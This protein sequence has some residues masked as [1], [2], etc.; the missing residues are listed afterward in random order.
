M[1]IECAV[2]S[3][4]GKLRSENEDNYFLN[5]IIRK[6]VTK[7]RTE[8]YLKKNGGKF[9]FAVCDGMGGEEQGELASLCSVKAMDVFLK[10]K[11]TEELYEHFLSLARK[12]IK[13]NTPVLKKG[14]PGTT[15]GLL[16]LEDNMAYAANLGDSRIYLWRG[17]ALRQLSKDHTQAQLMVDYGL[18]PKEEAREHQGGHVL[19]RCLSMD[20]DIS[21]ADFYQSEPID[22]YTDD[23]FLLC[24]DGLTDMLEDDEIQKC[25]EQY[26]D[27]N[28]GGQAQELCKRALL[29]GGKDNVTCLL[30]KI[31]QVQSK[32]KNK[33]FKRF[34]SFGNK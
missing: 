20:M 31:K 16:I 23:I 25:M 21:A 10:Q 6:D 26:S 28:V 11:R 7:N 34:T 24:S 22:L 12:Y 15:V 27:Y 30:V 2:Y 4:E 14:G 5:G 3:H 17:G 18:I 8:Q 9:V 13:T 1:K 29:A 33:I 32:Y 19:T